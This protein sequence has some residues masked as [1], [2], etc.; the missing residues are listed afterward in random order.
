M[1]FNIIKT[2]HIFSVISWMAGILY[3]PRIFVYHADPNISKET[4]STFKVMEK[5]LYQFIMLPSAT[6]TWLTGIAMIHFIGLEI[7]LL[8]KIFFV[9]LMSIYH[10]YC[11][12]WLNNFVNNNNPHSAKF[13]RL[14]NEVPAVILICILVL[15]VFKFF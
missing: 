3:L 1:I 5:R 4:Y 14:R 8:V 15:V 9:L 10:F 12:K 7:W 2:L 6:L 13:F 11:L